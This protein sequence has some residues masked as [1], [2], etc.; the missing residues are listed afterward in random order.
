MAFKKFTKIFFSKEKKVENLTLRKRYKVLGFKIAHKILPEKYVASC[1]YQKKN[2]VLY[3]EMVNK[4]KS[5]KKVIL[6]FDHSLGG[7]TETYFNNQLRHLKNN[8][9]I[10]RVQY[11]L[12]YKCYRLTLRGACKNFE[13][14]ESSLK[15]LSEEVA[16]AGL[17]TVVL[18]NIVGYPS[19]EDVFSAIGYLKNKNRYLK[20][21]LMGHDF[22]VVCPQWNL[23][24]EKWERCSLCL[25]S[26]NYQQ[27]KKNL[28]K[29]YLPKIVFEKE[30]NVDKWR[31]LWHN[32]IINYVD[33]FRCFSPSSGD[34]FLKAYPDIKDKLNL[35]PH[36]IEPFKNT[37][38]VAMIG[39]YCMHKG[40]GVIDSLLKYLGEKNIWDIHVYVF[41]SNYTSSVKSSHISFIGEYKRENLPDL[42]K[43]HHIDTIIIPSIWDETFSYTT[44]EAI[45]MDYPV[46]CFNFGGQGDQV[47]NYDKGYIIPSFDPEDVY[48]T[49]KKSCQIRDE[50]IVED[51]I[52][53]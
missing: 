13:L 21:I 49:L 43:L 22:Y 38:N 48:K 35:V 25:S 12:F 41:G 26:E 17:D 39:N 1:G 33:E 32:F 46:C 18:N 5:Y 16:K 40:S 9:I 52:N 27:C 28:P 31:D 53:G 42:L 23:L 19:I 4:L 51:L 11:M 2:S 14:Y 45:A 7:G 47:R 44:A 15:T 3:A 8:E 36:K 37:L 6:Y 10:I 34:I 29:I 50:E 30:F 20:I 24:D